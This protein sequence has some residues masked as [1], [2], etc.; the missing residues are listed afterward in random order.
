MTKLVKRLF[1]HIKIRT[2]F[3]PR[4]KR[5]ARTK[6]KLHKNLKKIQDGHNIQADI[7]EMRVMSKMLHRTQY[8]TT[9]HPHDPLKLD[10]MGHS[11]AVR[12]VVIRVDRQ[13]N[14]NSNERSRD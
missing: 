12:R 11:D 7:K 9:K 2:I 8:G 5:I 13:N 10:I 14:S 6:D 1:I 3:I 4:V